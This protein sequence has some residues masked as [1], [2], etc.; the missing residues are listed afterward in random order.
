M[1]L[2]PFK[3]VV[4]IVLIEEEDDTIVGEKVS[5]PQTF[6]GA[7]RLREFLDKFETDLKIE[8][9]VSDE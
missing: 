9:A 6:Y 3:F 1:S 7:D 5:E 2:K 8:A 4:Q